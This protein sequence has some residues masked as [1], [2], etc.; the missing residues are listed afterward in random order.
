MGQYHYV[1]NLDKKEFL[2]PHKLGCG[3]KAKEQIGSLPGTPAALFALLVCSNDRGGGDLDEDCAVVGRWAGDRIA[4]VGDYAEKR[5]LPKRKGCD[6]ADRIYDMCV[7]GAYQ[8]V[9][10]LLTDFLEKEFGVVYDGGD[11]GWGSWSKNSEEEPCTD[12]RHAKTAIGS[13]DR[14][15]SR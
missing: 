6:R 13:G 8:D 2:H 12:A 9:S 4:V 14:S 15:T 1:V 11:G 7:K 10:G 5:D 3:L